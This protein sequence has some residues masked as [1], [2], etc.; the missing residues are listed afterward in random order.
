[1]P[2]CVLLY[3]TFADV[4]TLTHSTHT[5]SLSLPPFFTYTHTLTHTYTHTHTHTL[6]NTLKQS[7]TGVQI[8]ES[9]SKDLKS[10]TMS[11]QLQQ[12]LGDAELVSLYMAGSYRFP[13][14][15]LLLF[16]LSRLNTA[17]MC[18]TIHQPTPKIP[19]DSPF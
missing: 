5:L 15:T 10:S 3:V 6:H 11:Q 8:L 9:Y 18:E 2:R 19:R 14:V 4:C 13:K 17:L 12:K 1:M 7:H 16:L